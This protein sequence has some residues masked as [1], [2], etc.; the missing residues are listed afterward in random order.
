M[1]GLEVDL[2]VM[3]QAAQALDQSSR[4]LDGIVQAL[5]GGIFTIAP[6]SFTLLDPG[7]GAEYAKARQEVIN[8]AGEMRNHFHALA[9]DLAAVAQTYGDTETGN[10]DGIRHSGDGLDNTSGI[11]RRLNA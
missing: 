9:M 10:D 7:A 11:S 4:D 6:G 1:S 3:V 2:Q 8:F 5:L